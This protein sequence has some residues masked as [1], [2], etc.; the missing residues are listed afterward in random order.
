MAHPVRK[1]Y[2]VMITTWSGLRRRVLSIPY[3]RA[4][5]SQTSIEEE[6]NESCV[7]LL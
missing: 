4:L 7:Y 5:N 6:P 3:L 2:W 1:T